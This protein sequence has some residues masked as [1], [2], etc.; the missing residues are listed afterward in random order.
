MPLRFLSLISLISHRTGEH[1]VPIRE[2]G[3][4]IEFLFRGGKTRKEEKGPRELA[5]IK[6][7]N[8]KAGAASITE[9]K[10]YRDDSLRV[11]RSNNLI[12]IRKINVRVSFSHA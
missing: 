7:N 3:H 2:F 10:I 1:F 9:H 8:D 12:A 5:V 11:N 6:Y 4:R